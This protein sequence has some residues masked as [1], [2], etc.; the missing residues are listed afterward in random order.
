VSAGNAYSFSPL[1]TGGAPL[2]LGLGRFRV[3]GYG[4]P[5]QAFGPAYVE[6]NMC[7]L[8]PRVLYS[9]ARG[10]LVGGTGRR[11][12]LL[13]AAALDD[14]AGTRKKMMKM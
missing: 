2:C 1:S 7:P 5:A 8:G 4:A 13:S 10:R 9:T 6:C 14:Y 3:P 11:F 12:E